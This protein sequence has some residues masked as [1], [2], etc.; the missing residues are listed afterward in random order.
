M[1][2]P[3]QINC[4]YA[5]AS[6]VNVDRATAIPDLYAHF[7]AQAEAG[8]FRIRVRAEIS[9]REMAFVARELRRDIEAH[10]LKSAPQHPMSI[11]VREHFP[12]AWE[13]AH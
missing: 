13:D 12:G 6:P 10:G 3:T 7:K 8:R 2:P 9:D 5:C 11:F 4:A 1:A